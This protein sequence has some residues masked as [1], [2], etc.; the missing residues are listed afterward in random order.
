MRTAPR[1]FLLGGTLGSL[2]SF[3]AFAWLVGQG[4]AD[5][6]VRTPYGNFNDAQARALLHGHW[7]VSPSELF[8]EGFRIGGKTY[9]YFGAWPSV[10]RMPIIEF[11]PSLY[12]RLTQ[13]S[14]L[15]AFAVLLAG[16]TALNW[17][18]RTILRPGAT[19]GTAEVVLTACIPIV[20][21]IGSTAFFLGSRAW[22]Y[23]EAILWGVAWSIVAFERLL[24]FTS[25]PSAGRLAAASV[26]AMLAFTSRGAVGMGPVV[27]LGLVCAGQFLQV[28]REKVKRGPARSG[29]R[30]A[31]TDRSPTWLIGTAVAFVFPAVVYMYVNWSRFGTLISVPWS[32]QVLV[33]LRPGGSRVLNA[34]GG[35]YFGLNVAPTTLLQYLRPDALAFDRLFPWLTFQHFRTPVIGNAVIDALDS[36]SSLPASMPGIFILA[37]LGVIAAVSPRYARSAGAR[38]LRVPLLGAA[39]AILPTV[40]IAFVAQRYLADFLPLLTIGALAGLHTL[41]RRRTETPPN[42]RR[43]TTAI[44]VG[45]GVLSAFG[46]WANGSLAFLYQRL[47]NPFPESNRA[48][49][50]GFQYRIDRAI[51]SGTNQL[52]RVTAVARRPAPAG[53][54]AIV[55]DCAALYWSDGRTWRLVEG[56]PGGGVFRIEASVPPAAPRLWRPLI[57]WGAPGAQDVIGVRRTGASVQVSLAVY[58]PGRELEFNRFELRVA[59]SPQTKHVFEVVVSDPLHLVRVRIDGVDVLILDREPRLPQGTINI[60][61]AETSGVAPDYGS[62]IRRLHPSNAVCRQIQSG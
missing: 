37:A 14:L 41:L 1:R 7:N 32:K 9:T 42:Q 29:P 12:G 60:G 38:L 2:V 34:N 23:H 8:Y 56:A 21:G 22:V 11:A 19:V 50:L 15:L 49:T 53:T 16:V 18:I 43:R 3:A 27:A 10:L 48:G 45:I 33:G 17:R 25:A 26:A 46:I 28:V 31:P 20:V 5:L 39:V 47:Y 36:T 58:Q 6:L 51:S 59:L 57:A 35:S 54:T 55:G 44:L 4:R 13:L 62:P 40:F 24:A 52:Q 30:G 61:H